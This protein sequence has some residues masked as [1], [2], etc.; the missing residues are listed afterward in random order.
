MAELTL[1]PCKGQSF[2]SCFVSVDNYEFDDCSFEEVLFVSSGGPFQFRGCQFGKA[3]GVVYQG[4]AMWTLEL[5]EFFRANLG[6]ARKVGPTG[7]GVQGPDGI[8]V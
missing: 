8:P 7:G 2:R 4:A 5:E 6:P 3:C 1:V